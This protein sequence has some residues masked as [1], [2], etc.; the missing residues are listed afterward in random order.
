MGRSADAGLV[1]HF[2]QRQT[3]E[4]IVDLAALPKAWREL[5]IED[6]KCRILHSS[7]IEPGRNVLKRGARPVFVGGLVA[8]A[9]RHQGEP[10]H[11]DVSVIKVKVDAVT[12][13][14]PESQKIYRLPVV[15]RAWIFCQARNEKTLLIVLVDEREHLVGPPS[16]IS[17]AG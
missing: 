3:G 12:M 17:Y 10:T 13:C 11:S 6:L 5:S 9:L 14:G 16:G 2:F 7:M 15:L 8:L 4:V 1:G